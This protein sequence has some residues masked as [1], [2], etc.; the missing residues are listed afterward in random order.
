MFLTRNAIKKAVEDGDII[1]QPFEPKHLSPN[2]IDV[3]LNENLMVYELQE[4]ECLDMKKD[5]PTKHLIIPEEG[6]VLQPN[7]LYIGMTNESA[8]SHSYIPMFEG[9]SS[10]GRLG[11]NTH[12][13]AGFGDLGWGFEKL[14]NGEVICHYPTW[15]LEIAVVHPIRVYP[16]VRIGQVY[17]VEPKG[18]IEW[19]TGKYSKQRMPQPSRSFKD[20]GS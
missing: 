15:T 18:D 11:I 17:F 10:I 4:G 6:L 9:R 5:N 20:F 8:I 1:I 14:E 7:I 13:T 2:S 12:I 16:G 3:T 19:Y